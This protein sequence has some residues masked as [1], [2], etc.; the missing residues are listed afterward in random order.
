MELG[1]GVDEGG[2][3]LPGLGLWLLLWRVADRWLS[4]ED[5][6]S[7]LD[8]RID[9]SVGL[10]GGAGG[11]LWYPPK[12]VTEVSVRCSAGGGVWVSSWVRKWSSSGC[13]TA[14]SFVSEVF[15]GR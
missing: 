2:D 10:G 13:G 14:G 7:L 5:V 1:E 11:A 8:L 6:A 9:V 3:C 4:A 12:L 15:E